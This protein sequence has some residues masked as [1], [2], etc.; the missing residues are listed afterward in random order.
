MR[1]PVLILVF[2]V[3]FLAAPAAHGQLRNPAQ[4]PTAGELIGGGQPVTLEALISS[5]YS[6]SV[7]VVGL[8][9][10]LMLL[11]AGV[12]R[13]MGD[14]QGSNQIIIDTLIGTVL[15]LSSVLILNSINPDTTT[16]QEPVFPLPQEG[17]QSQ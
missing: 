11:Y 8:C 3:V 13:L 4:A 16:Q 14:A 15:L 6:A 2:L 1:I 17:G 9:A 10:F 5:L 7:R 12:R